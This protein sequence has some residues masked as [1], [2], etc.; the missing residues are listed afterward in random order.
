MWKLTQHKV[1][2]GLQEHRVS[3][4]IRDIML[5]TYATS[6]YEF[7]NTFNLQI[8]DIPKTN[9]YSCDLMYKVFCLDHKSLE[10]W[11]LTPEGF[12]KFRFFTLKFQ[13]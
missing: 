8:K 6:S 2:K 5:Y 13:K 11:K 9:N 1:P 3:L 10:V 7:E 12:K 4:L